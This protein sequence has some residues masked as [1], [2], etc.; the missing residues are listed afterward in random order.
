MD[1]TTAFRSHW[2]AA[3]GTR[4]ATR[5]L[6]SGE[7]RMDLLPIVNRDELLA[8]ADLA[9]ADLPEAGFTSQ[10]MARQVYY[11]PK[12]YGHAQ[13]ALLVE[14]LTDGVPHYHANW[15]QPFID[16]RNRWPGVDGQPVI[17]H[18]DTPVI[19][20]RANTEERPVVGDPNEQCCGATAI[21]PDNG[22]NMQCW[23]GLAHDPGLGHRYFDWIW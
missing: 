8:Y 18:V 21:T 22:V 10:W 12:V 2:V 13:I 14:E 17:A 15:R 5:R 6:P 20:R 7:K 4:H 9:Y 11:H 1:I 19:A 3:D 23:R 16:L